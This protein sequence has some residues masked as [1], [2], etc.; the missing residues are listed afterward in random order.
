MLPTLRPNRHL[1]DALDQRMRGA[2]DAYEAIED[3]YDGAWEAQ[4]YETLN[5]E[6]L[7][8][9]RITAYRVYANLRDAARIASKL[10]RG[11]SL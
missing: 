2:E 5:S 6:G 3:L 8:R 7:H 4:D 1:V 9:A 11:D 10:T